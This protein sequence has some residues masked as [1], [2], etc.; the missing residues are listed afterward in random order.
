MCWIFMGWL[1]DI[2]WYLTV[3]VKWVNMVFADTK[4]KFQSTNFVYSPRH[5]YHTNSMHSTTMVDLCLCCVVAVS[6]IGRTIAGD[7]SVF[8]EAFEVLP[9]RQMSA[10]KEYW[11]R[12]Q[13]LRL[14]PIYN[15]FFHFGHLLQFF[16]ADIRKLQDYFNTKIWI[17]L[18]ICHRWCFWWK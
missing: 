11:S 8:L 1:C 10:G 13:L 7:L 17:T 9:F 4:L 2:C 3:C 15:F 12:V 5:M 18:W 14:L 6:S 16:G